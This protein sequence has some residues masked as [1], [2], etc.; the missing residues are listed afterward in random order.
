[1]TQEKVL[2]LNTRQ[3]EHKIERIAHQIIEFN[4]EEAAIAFI[5]IA[6]QGFIL[7]EKLKGYVE[8]NSDIKV[9]LIKMS[10]NKKK[11]L[12]GEFEFSADKS[13]LNNKSVILVDDVLNSGRTLI[14]AAKEVLNYPIMKLT[15]VVLVDRR[16]RKFPIKADFVGL[17]LST[18]I[19]EHITVELTKGQE[20]VYLE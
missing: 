4:Y 7:A 18:T 11:P 9:N 17:T 2:I 20:A 1:M 16:H 6:T 15:T 14:Y 12:S 3:I 8:A 13:A 19:Q 10:M 5:G